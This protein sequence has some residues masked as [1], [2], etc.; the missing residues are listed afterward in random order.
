MPCLSPAALGV[1]RSERKSLPSHLNQPSGIRRPSTGGGYSPLALLWA[2]PPAPCPHSSLNTPWSSLLPRIS[3]KPEFLRRSGRCG[4]RTSRRNGPDAYLLSYAEPIG[5]ESKR[6]RTEALTSLRE[7]A[8][9]GV[10]GQ[11][12]LSAVIAREVNAFK[13]NRKENAKDMNKESLR[14]L[15]RHASRSASKRNFIKTAA[16][17][18]GA[19]GSAASAVGSVASSVGGA[20]GSVAGAVGSAAVRAGGAVKS[21][22]GHIADA[23]GNYLAPAPVPARGR[24]RTSRAPKVVDPAPVPAPE[25]DVAIPVAVHPRES[26]HR[27]EATKR[28]IDHTKMV[29]N[30]NGEPHAARVANKEYFKSFDSPTRDAGTRLWTTQAQVDAS[31]SV[32]SELSLSGML[33]RISLNFSQT[34]LHTRRTEDHYQISTSNG[35]PCR[36]S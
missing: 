9:K 33:F 4:R 12:T 36:E 18:A 5:T 35:T 16:K 23:V 26:Y 14:A 6:R 31:E 8:K 22:A 7:H 1:P 30:A 20:V 10:K 21:A 15:Q 29:F 17:V 24:S 27:A 32:L 3:C 2:T 34:P 19:V 13:V 25:P 11:K 28:G